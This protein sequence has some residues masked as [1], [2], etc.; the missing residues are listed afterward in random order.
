M[1]FDLFHELLFVVNQDP[2]DYESVGCVLCI[3][4]TETW[5]YGQHH[6]EDILA[7]IACIRTRKIE[8][9]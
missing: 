9:Y 6:I 7:K 3:A 4:E 5:T 1:Q 8:Q 2:F